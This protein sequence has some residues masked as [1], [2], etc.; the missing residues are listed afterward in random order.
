MTELFS[1]IIHTFGSTSALKAIV[2]YE[3]K[4]VGADMQYRFNYKILITN[5]AGEDYGY[6]N[7]NNNLQAVFTLN[8]TNVWTQ[9]TQSS[10]VSWSFEYT[11]DW[12]TVE[13]KTTGTVPFK[14]TIKDT[15]N[16]SWCNYTSTTYSLGVDPA[17]SD[18]GAVANFNIGNAITVPIT[19]YASM[20]DVL[21]VKIGST[22]IKTMNNVNDPA[23]VTFTSSELN[24][25]YS[26]TKNDKKRNLHSF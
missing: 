8:G 25:I 18:I 21:V 17:G 10:A 4:R 3:K 13:N 16:S 9:N 20:Y 7:Y 23:T 22:T 2:S 19:K 12:F 24:T 5:R 14:F 1:G 15:I 6:G 26:L 11:S